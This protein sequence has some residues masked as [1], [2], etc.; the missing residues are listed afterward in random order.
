MTSLAFPSSSLGTPAQYEGILLSV[1]PHTP[2]S[3]TRPLPVLPPLPPRGTA[4][5]SAADATEAAFAITH[6][7]QLYSAWD[8][9]RS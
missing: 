7:V 2:P 8:R 5:A 3:H 6:I 9:V 4:S 1:F